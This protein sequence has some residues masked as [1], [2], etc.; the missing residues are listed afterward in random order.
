MGLVDRTFKRKDTIIFEQV[1]ALLSGKG[2]KFRRDGGEGQLFKFEANVDERVIGCLL[3]CDMNRSLLTFSAILP[4]RIPNN[5]MV[6]SLELIARFNEKIWYGAFE[7]SFEYNVVSFVTTL[8]IDNAFISYEQLERLCF[9][10]LLN[11]H[12]FQE[13]FEKLLTTNLKVVEIY[14]EIITHYQNSGQ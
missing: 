13:G 7:F 2:I 3:T 14:N 1:S 8:P 5:K 4:Y 10:N 6:E 12:F 11:V 9:N